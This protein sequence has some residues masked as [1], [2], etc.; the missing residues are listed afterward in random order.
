MTLSQM[1]QF[2]AV[3]HY[4]NVT[5]AAAALHITQP[6][7]SSSIKDLEA[8]FGIN[9]FHRLN[10]RLT[11]TQ[12]G[13]FYLEKVTSV[14]VQVDNLSEQ[15]RDMGNKKNL[16]HIGVP[17]MIGTFLF[18]TM[19]DAFHTLNPCINLEILEHGS[20]RTRQMVKNDDLDIAIAIMD[21]QADPELNR[22]DILRT[23]LYYCVSPEHHMSD[24]AEISIKDLAEEPLIL[25]KPDSSQNAIVNEQFARLGITPNVMLSSS[26]LYTIKK[27]MSKGRAGAFLFKEIADM[28]DDIV[29][30]P[31]SSPIVM[32]ICLIWKKNRFIYSD[33]S[34][35]IAFTK[36]Y[37]WQP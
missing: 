37:K 4:K 12:E 16:I 30:I 1:R 3:C 28:E 14:L 23:S 19:Y 8:E 27:F 31:L 20:L 32:D 10:K 17:P 21:E 11:L 15:M 24:R 9:L 2:Q 36:E 6:S 5:R 34:K 13:E 26:Q 33:A 7:V 29:G 22:L 35:F 25:F 18:P